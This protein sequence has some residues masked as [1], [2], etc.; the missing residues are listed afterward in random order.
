ME[1][2]L[3]RFEKYS[4]NFDLTSLP[5]VHLYPEMAGGQRGGLRCDALADNHQKGLRRTYSQKPPGC[6][7]RG[8]GG[9]DATLPFSVIP[10]VGREFSPGGA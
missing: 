6:L 2:L 10:T 1:R 4:C 8:S 7:V 3:H 9:L 5:P